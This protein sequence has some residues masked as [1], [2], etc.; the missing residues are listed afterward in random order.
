MASAVGLVSIEIF[1]YR[2]V[3]CRDYAIQLGLALQMT[4]IIRGGVP[5]SAMP[6]WL[7]DYGGPLTDQQIAALV[8]YIRSWEP[9]APSR[10]DWR[11]PGGG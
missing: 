10:S 3:A 11:T 4:N 7:A 8:A 2:N 5:G 1:G 6:A 9:T